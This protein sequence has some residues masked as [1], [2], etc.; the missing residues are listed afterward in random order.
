MTDID[1]SDRAEPAAVTEFLR[2]A[3]A[4]GSTKC[5]E[6]DQKERTACLTCCVEEA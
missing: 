3:A 5:N 4:S 2:L 6:H 1:G